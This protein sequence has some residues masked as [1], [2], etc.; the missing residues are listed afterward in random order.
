MKKEEE[1]KFA[2]SEWLRKYIPEIQIRWEKKNTFGY[3]TFRCKGSG[4]KPDLMFWIPKSDHNEMLSVMEVKNGEHNT[5]LTDSAK[6]VQYYKL[7]RDGVLRYFVDDI[8]FK[9]KYFLVASKYSPEGFLCGTDCRNVPMKRKDDEWH[10]WQPVCE[11]PIC[12]DFTRFLWK[13]WKP[14]KDPSY[15]LGVLLSDKLDGGTGWPAIFIQKY[16]WVKLKWNPPHYF[17]K[18][19]G[20]RGNQ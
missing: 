7:S 15:C 14:I 18:L 13:Q 11:Y 17:W 16:N 2:L 10:K 9:P 1:T 5:N 19:G 20:E 6:I 4:K 8:E 3:K 12:F